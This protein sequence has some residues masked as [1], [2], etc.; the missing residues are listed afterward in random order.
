MTT[1][2]QGQK[3]RIIGGLKAGLAGDPDAFLAVLAPDIV[4]H[5]PAYLPF[6]G[7]HRGR[8]QVLG[9][10]QEAGKI[11]DFATL[12][13]LSALADG[14]C[15]AMLMS[16]DLHDGSQR[17]IIEHWQVGADGLVSE[18]RVFWDAAP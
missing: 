15:L 13:I 11:I 18:V 6:A 9:I 7:V 12:K 8:E 17:H 3:E 16:V 14:D 4:I 5:E 10:M 2:V 1:T